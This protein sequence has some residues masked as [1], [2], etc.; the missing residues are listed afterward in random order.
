MENK[1]F[2]ALQII[3]LLGLTFVFC[4]SLAVTE[5]GLG[6]LQPKAEAVAQE[7]TSNMQTYIVWV[8]KPVRKL[9][10]QSHEDLESWYQSFL[11]K[12]FATSNR[13]MRQRMV[14][15]YHHVATGFAAKLTAEEVKEMETKDGFVSAH[16]ERI[17]PLH[18]THSPNFLG[19]VP[20]IGTLERV[21][22]W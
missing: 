16:P 7:Y 19:F 21:K 3:Y 5:E 8:K 14:Y 11:P 22:L 20:R 13:V 1:K 10:S 9:F 2:V 17:L 6:A 4:L 15:T 18:T 12:T